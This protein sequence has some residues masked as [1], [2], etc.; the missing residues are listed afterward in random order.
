[1]KNCRVKRKVM[2]DYIGKR[3]FEWL[4]QRNGL[5]GV[6]YTKFIAHNVCSNSLTLYNASNNSLHC[7]FENID[8]F[9]VIRSYIKDRV[10]MYIEIRHGNEVCGYYSS[11][12]TW[13]N[14]C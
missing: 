7:V 2:L 11:I 5:I 12:P 1:M 4:K 14:P 8:L 10:R 6:Y 13:I 9:N 3:R